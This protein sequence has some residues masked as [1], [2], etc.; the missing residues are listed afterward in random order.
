M[1]AELYFHIPY[2]PPSQQLLEVAHAGVRQQQQQPRGA[3]GQAAVQQLDE[4]E[5][6]ILIRTLLE[7]NAETT[8]AA[9]VRL[10]SRWLLTACTR[11]VLTQ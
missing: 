8:G 9:S 2:R 7:A 11:M 6:R 5:C 10:P 3:Q 4:V 1:P